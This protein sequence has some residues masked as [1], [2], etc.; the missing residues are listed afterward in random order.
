MF[1]MKRIICACMC[2]L[3]LCSCAENTAQIEAV[4]RG[5]SYTAHIFYY[6]EEYECQVKVEENGKESYLVTKPKNLKDFT[7]IFENEEVVAEYKNLKFSPELSALPQGSVLK[8]LHGVIKY[9]ESNEYT[10]Y[11][12]KENFYING[13]AD[14]L[15]FKLIIAESGLPLSVE[16]NNEFEVIFAS[17]S[18]I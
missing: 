4:T 13:M 18:Y 8:E 1:F 11:K 10:V 17:V 2:L 5:I 16:F 6:G 14:S 3:L 12:S 7:I 9:I 15:E